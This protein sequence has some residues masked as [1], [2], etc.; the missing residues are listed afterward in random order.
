[1]H[2]RCAAAA[3]HLAPVC[4]VP[5]QSLLPRYLHPARQY[6]HRHG[7]ARMS[8]LYRFAK[9]HDRANTHVFTFVVTRSVTRDLERDVTSKQFA[10][11]YQRWAITFS[12]TDKVLG[13]YL[14]WR[15]PAEGMRVYVDF[16]FTLLNREHFSV[17]EAFSG[18]Q[19]KFTFDSPA[20]G[21]RNYIPVS[22]LYSRNFT[23]TNGEFQLELTMGNLRTA[24]DAEFRV[25]QSVWSSLP[26]H[27]HRHH[28]HSHSSAA[29][30]GGSS[31]SSHGRSG[32]ASSAPASTAT[33]PT[34]VVTTG[35]AHKLEST[36]FTFGGFD[37]NLALYPHGAKEIGSGSENRVSVYLNRLTG[38]D[39]R[40]RVRYSVSLG[41]AERRLDSGL[42][43]DVSD[44][45][46]KGYGWH[47]RARFSDLVYKGLVRLH[48]ELLA[49]NTVSEV[50]VASAPPHPTA[51]PPAALLSAA[52]ATPV[53]PQPVVAQCY[54]RD[55]QAWTIKSD[56][57]AETVRLHMVYKDIHNVPRNHLRY[58]L[59]F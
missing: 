5:S 26:L 43:D 53:L 17:N 34:P 51:P 59:L 15:N 41:D 47:P 40:C 35:T 58:G 33:S 48:L 23:D 52:P 14:V 55:K 54:D 45:D 29:S 27:P 31:S 3:G 11:G 22:D 13:V 4:S 38:F 16:T 36:Y 18:K 25:P 56:C 12:R 8:L 50:A 28:R 39:H 30:G 21:N 10:C 46:G 1:M 57:H 2:A 6:Y 37:W 49:A 7:V 20:Q 42:L 9:L 24:F 32:P 44:S 19:V